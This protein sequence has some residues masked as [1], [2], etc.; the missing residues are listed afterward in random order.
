MLIEWRSEVYIKDGV[1]I[2]GKEV[3]GWPCI[4]IVGGPLESLI[5]LSSLI[6]AEVKA[7][8]MLYTRKLC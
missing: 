5:I 3:N 4:L 1:I 6:L 2:A 7:N 8:I